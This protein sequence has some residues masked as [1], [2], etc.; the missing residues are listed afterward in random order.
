[1]TWSQ[2]WNR[3]INPRYRYPTNIGIV[4]GT[5]LVATI[6]VVSAGVDI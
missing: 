3:Q 1:M 6:V 5:V 2:L 4:R